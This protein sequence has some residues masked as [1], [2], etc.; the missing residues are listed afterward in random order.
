M[1][2]SKLEINKI[3]IFENLRDDDRLTGQE[4]FK[5]VQYYAPLLEAKYQPVNDK[6]HL[7]SA[8]NSLVAEANEDDGIILFIESH[9]SERGIYFSD[10]L[11]TWS[12]IYEQLSEINEK[13]CM[14]L[15]VIFSCC[16]GVNFYKTTSILDKCP[17][18][19]MLGFN[20]S[21][22]ENKLFE[23]NKLIFNAL[24]DG[25]ETLDI[26]REVN[27]LLP[28]TKTKITILDAGDVFDNAIRNYLTSSMNESELK[29]RAINNHKEHLIGC[30]K[31]GTTA[32]D[33]NTFQKSM[34]EKLLSKYYLEEQ[35][36]KLKD[37]FLL[38]DKYM[39]LN[40][41]FSSI[42]DSIYDELN[43]ENVHAKILSKLQK[44]V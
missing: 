5:H 4:M 37:R 8:L 33:F 24:I 27:L 39:H 31:V 42:F 44:V 40:C 15:I 9:G 17:Y 43:V 7:L 34:Y 41:R 3:R 30:S 20:G 16:Y 35:F 36:Y 12:E 14:G 22:D 25:E 13:S 2:V 19:L 38:T 23:C 6:L 26:E 32:Y 28:M 11:I 29:E 18:Y 21:I 1:N 10:E